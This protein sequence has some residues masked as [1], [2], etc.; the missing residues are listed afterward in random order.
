[1]TGP[2]APLYERIETIRQ[3]R[4]MS[5]TALIRR[6]GIGRNTYDRLPDT[7]R[8]HVSTVA[9]LAHALDLDIDEARAL[10]GLTDTKQVRVSDVADGFAVLVHR[11]LP[12]MDGP[13]IAKVLRAAAFVLSGAAIELDDPEEK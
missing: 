10:A 4:G 3:R 8:P 5:K 11:Q 12:D 7:P 1:M 13:T 2:A 9:A 6:A